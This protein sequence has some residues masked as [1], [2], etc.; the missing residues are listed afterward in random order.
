MDGGHRLDPSQRLNLLRERAEGLTG[1]ELLS[2]AWQELG[3]RLAVVSSFGAESAVLLHLVSQVDP[4]IPVIFLETGKHFPETL[5]YRDR[6]CG[7][8][9]LRDVR[10]IRPEPADLEQADRD[11]RLWARKPDHCCHLRKVLPLQRALG[12]FD[13]WVTGRK[14]YQAGSRRGLPSLEL[15]GEHI[16]VNPLA[17]WTRNDVE[18]VMAESGLPQHPL[19][20]EGYPSIGCLPCTRRPVEGGGERSGRW[21]GTNKT[22]CGIHKAWWAKGD[23]GSSI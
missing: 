14:R 21:A 19:V 6:L 15:D 5:M 11:G 20:A 3:T 10:S 7:R 4:E 13:A 18:R 17:T 22:E 9:G 16:K 8:L 12:D 23:E 2:V 1:A